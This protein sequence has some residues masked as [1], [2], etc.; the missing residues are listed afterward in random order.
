MPLFVFAM[1]VGIV[2]G[3]AAALR[4]PCKKP[5]RGLCVDC[6]FVHMQYGATGRS[7]VFCTF[8]GGVR[9]VKLDVLYCTDYQ[10]RNA[11]PRLVR[12]GFAPRIR[13]VS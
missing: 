3:L 9:E 1:L 6:A 2:R 11:V 8:G 4:R 5:A 7:A 12:I 13:G 10:D